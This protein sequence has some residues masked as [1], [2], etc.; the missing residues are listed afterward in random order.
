[1]SEIVRKLLETGSDELR[2]MDDRDAVF[3]AGYISCALDSAKV[4]P[5]E[6]NA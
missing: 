4:K 2:K 6:E 3:L 1:M 5:H